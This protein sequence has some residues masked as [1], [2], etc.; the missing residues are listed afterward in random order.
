MTTRNKIKDT[1]IK[2]NLIGNNE[3]VTVALSG[4]FDSVCLLHSLWNLGYKVQ[5]AHLNHRLRDE[6]DDDMEYVKHLTDKMG[7]ELFC[8]K[9]EVGIYAKENKLSTETAGRFLRYEFFKEITDKTGGV[10]ATAHNSNDNAESFMMHLIRGSGL[11]GLTGIRPK[12]EIDGCRVIRPLIE[13][14]RSEIEQYCL[15]YNLQPRLDKTNTTTDYQRNEIRHIVMPPIIERDGIKAISRACQVIT[16]EEDFLCEYT[17]NLI[18]EY[19]QEYGNGK[20]YPLKW[21]NALPL[22]IKR[23]VIR[24]TIDMTWQHPVALLHT[25][26]VISACEKNYGGK[27]IQI[28]GKFTA[29]IKKGLVIIEHKD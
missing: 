10:V 28:P 21:F 3:L 23:R 2:Y 7:I 13:V 18:N 17:D 29:E 6:A 25:D 14:E 26:N 11:A 22:A 16:P 20:A 27:I 9:I 15:K 5:A 12:T 19:G 8:K 1:I 4:G 24:R